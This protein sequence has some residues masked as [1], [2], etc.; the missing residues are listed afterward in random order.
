MKLVRYDRNKFNDHNVHKQHFNAARALIEAK[1]NDM[2]EKSINLFAATLA[3]SR[4]FLADKVMMIRS[5][6]RSRIDTS[7]AGVAIFQ[8]TSASN[9]SALITSTTVP[10]LSPLAELFDEIKVCGISFDYQPYNP[11][12]RGG[13][14]VSSL[15]F[16][17]DDEAVFN[18]TNSL[19]GMGVIVNRAPL[20]KHFAPD[21]SC[22][23]TFRRPSPMELYD[24]T[25]LSNL[26]SATST[27][28]SFFI[29][30]DGSSS[31]NAY[32]GDVN[33]QFLLM[34]RARV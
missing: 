4:S 2:D 31:V 5:G 33:Y 8:I 29:G 25:P 34:L 7:G 11:Y 9:I 16:G 32:F 26:G 20:V 3:F 17:W 15:M 13:T 22:S 27:I 18:P 28:G 30:G 19:V 24:W 6:S 14:N 1:A 12:N 10:E 21:H 23:H